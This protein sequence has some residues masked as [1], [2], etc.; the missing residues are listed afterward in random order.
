MGVGFFSLSTHRDFSYYLHTSLCLFYIFKYFHIVAY[1]FFISVW[2]LYKR[3]IYMQLCV[4]SLAIF[5][6]L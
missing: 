4:C 1:Y 2:F 3:V 6:F 5:V